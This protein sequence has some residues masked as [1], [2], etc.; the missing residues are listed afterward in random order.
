MRLRTTVIAGLIALFACSV[1]FIVN[2]AWK[3]LTV[4]SQPRVPILEAT[5]TACQASAKEGYCRALVV[6][7][8]RPPKAGVPLVKLNGEDLAWERAEAV[9]HEVLRTRMDPTVFLRTD[10]VVSLVSKDQMIDI[11][12]RAS[13][14]KICVI[15]TSDPPQWYPPHCPGEGGGMAVSKLTAPGP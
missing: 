10:P 4:S 14:E 9:L 2:R 5:G 7:L 15:D 8:L 11:I 13:A 12:R 6:E 3:K 1:F